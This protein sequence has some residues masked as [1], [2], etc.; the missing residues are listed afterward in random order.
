MSDAPIEIP[1]EKIGEQQIQG[2]ELVST[3][4]LSSHPGILKIKTHQPVFQHQILQ[5]HPHSSSK[6]RITP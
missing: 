4:R 1:L 2:Q 6:K 5:I 3:K